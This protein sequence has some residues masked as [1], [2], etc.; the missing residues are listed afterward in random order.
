MGIAALRADVSDIV[1][2]GQPT[3]LRYFLPLSLAV[4]LAGALYCSGYEALASGRDQWP[5]SLLWSIYSIVPWL[6]F[7]EWVKRSR[8]ADPDSMGPPMVVALIVFTVVVSLAAE[9]L[10]DWISGSQSAPLGLLIM[11]RLPAVGAAVLLLTLG[12]RRPATSNRPSVGPLSDDL[13]ELKFHASSICWVKAADNYLEF[14]FEDH[15][16]TRRMTM[17]N[18][19]RVLEN[20]GFVRTHRSYLVNRDFVEEIANTGGK[21]TVRMNDGTCLP[22]GKA[23]QASF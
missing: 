12:K 20:H 15:V 22:V 16:W 9:F 7:Y 1:L 14:H 2:H 18:A 19:T 5:G 8:H 6:F 13:E 21:V 17:Q 23:F 11:R 10:V 4:C 3:P